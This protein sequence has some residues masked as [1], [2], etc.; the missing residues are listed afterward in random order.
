MRGNDPD[1]AE[2]FAKVIGTKS[3]VKVTERRKISFL[4]D[5]GTGDVSARDVE[6]F[7]FHPNCF[8][9]ELGVGEAVMVV[10][11][12]RGSKTVRIKFDKYPDL[13]V[14]AM[15]ARS[16][17]EPAGLTE[18]QKSH[19]KTEQSIREVLQIQ[20]KEPTCTP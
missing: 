12:E 6:E 8:K 7:I 2:H 19:R 3:A 5:Q 20:Q 18:K 14:V 16:H 4:Q 13:P 10:P 17:S 15:P 1:S 11:H 9:R